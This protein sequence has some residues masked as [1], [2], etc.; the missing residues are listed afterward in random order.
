MIDV[1]AQQFKV[2]AVGMKQGVPTIG[3]AG[4]Y[5]HRRSFLAI[6][7]RWRGSSLPMGSVEDASKNSPALTILQ[8]RVRI[9]VSLSHYGMHRVSVNIGLPLPAGACDRS[10]IGGRS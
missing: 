5:S 4:A 7:P 6:E 2:V 8:K 3:F 1:E 10:A 9:F